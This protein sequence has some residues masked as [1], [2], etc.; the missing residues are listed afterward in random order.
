M[1]NQ[2]ITWM[3]NI[4]KGPISWLVI[5]FLVKTIYTIAP[6]EKIPSNKVNK[7]AIFT[8]FAWI[9]GTLIYSYYIT[10]FA[11]Y[12]LFYGSL[13]NLVVLMIWFYY[14]AFILTVGIAINSEELNS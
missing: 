5:F 8:T 9:I 14:L 3:V 13:T 2:Q 6:D 7:G 1:I 11:H 4:L 12:S 10:H